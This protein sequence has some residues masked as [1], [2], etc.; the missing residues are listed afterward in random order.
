VSY[1]F[2][3]NYNLANVP[4]DSFPGPPFK[5]WHLGSTYEDMSVDP[6]G[7]A[8]VDDSVARSF[9]KG[10]G[11]VIEEEVTTTEES[12]HIDDDETNEIRKRS[13]LDGVVLSRKGVYRVLESRITA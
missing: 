11:T 3:A 10:N 9:N 1:N 4:A 12:N 6:A 13:L 2:E 7:D 5:R 8:A